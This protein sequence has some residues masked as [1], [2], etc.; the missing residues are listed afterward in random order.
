VNLQVTLYTGDLFENI[1]CVLI[2]KDQ[3]NLPAFWQFCTSQIFK[4]AVR[5][6]NQKL[7]VDVRYFEKA[8]FD[9]EYWRK[10]ARHAHPNGLPRP[11][12]NDA[13]Q[14]LFHGRPTGSD[15]PLQVA[16]A[17]MLGYRWPLQTGSEFLDSPAIKA[18]GLEKHA[19]PDGIV[20][21]SSIKGRPAADERLRALLADA[22]GV[23]WSATKLPAL[24]SGVGFEGDSLDDWLR[25]GF[26]AQHCELFLQRPFIWHIWDGRRDGFNALVN[27]H[28][29]AGPKSEARG[30]L[31]KLIFTYLGG[32]IE[33]QRE[34]QKK[35]VEGADGRLAAAI[36]LQSE[37]K[38]ILEGDQPYD[39][40]VRWK[41]LRGQAIGWGPD[42]NDGIRVNIRPFMTAR[43]KSARAANA[44]I[45]RVTP[46]NIKW[47]KDRGKEPHRAKDDFPWFWGWD[48]ETIDFAGGRTFDGNRWNDLH[49]TIKAK[50][51]A[52]GSQPVPKAQAGQ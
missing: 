44:C 24:L 12:S 31:E 3:S 30:T 38:N 16:V 40:F 20:C 39:L 13:T 28:R 22:Y 36:N 4:D 21:L 10:T 37:L 34:D 45:L 6:V 49:Y 33:V 52:Q 42:L 48:E 29:L 35:G 51:E 27:Y 43:L 8:V 25:D 41:P 18:D 19:D 46:K 23:D 11:H 7:S 9:L 15:E 5:A 50:R 17:R 32:W 2:P 26:F 1:I 14:W 47:E